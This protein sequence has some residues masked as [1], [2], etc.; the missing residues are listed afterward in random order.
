MDTL[1]LFHS[2]NEFPFGT[3]EPTEY[4]PFSIFFIGFYIVIFVL[5]I[6]G[7]SLVCYVVFHNPR[8]QTITNMLITSLCLSHIL[9]CIF[10]IPFVLIYTLKPSEYFFG[11]FFCHLSPYVYSLYHF[12][13]IYE[14]LFYLT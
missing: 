2:G 10:E 3:P 1:I 14:K 5:G 13:N 8:M 7:N 12:I 4:I 9:F 11:S 6:S